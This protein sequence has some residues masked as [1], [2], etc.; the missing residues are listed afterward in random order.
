MRRTLPDESL[1][2]HSLLVF[3]FAARAGWSPA[4]AMLAGALRGWPPSWAMSM[5]ENSWRCGACVKID[6][7]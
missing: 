2:E 5:V 1:I 4:R 7:T 6:P 3:S